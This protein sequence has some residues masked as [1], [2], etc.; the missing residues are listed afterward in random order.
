MGAYNDD[1]HSFTIIV[2]KEDEDFSFQFVDQMVDVADYTENNFENAKLLDDI[3]RYRFNFPMKLEFY[4][5]R[6][7][8]K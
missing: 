1:Y 6:N 5:L 8:K 7:K 3:D 4:Q 2:H